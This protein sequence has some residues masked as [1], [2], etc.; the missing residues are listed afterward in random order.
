MFTM[1][2]YKRPQSIEEAFE[3]LNAKKPNCILGGTHF[4]KMG[5]K[6]IAT[7]ID[8]QDVGLDY[9]KEE[10]GVIKIG[11]MTSLRTM[12]E[13]ELLEKH[14]GNVFKEAFSG[15][16]GI[17]LRNTATI[18]ASVHARYGFS[19]TCLVLLALEASVKLY[20]KEIIAIEQYLKE[21]LKKDFVTEI[22]I[23]IKT[24][25][26]TYK[27]YRK[28]ATDLSVLNVCVANE[29]G[30][31]PRIAVGA[32]PQRATLAKQAMESF[33]GDI[34]KTAITAKEEIIV[35]SNMR[36][37]SEYRSHLVKVLVA[38]ALQEVI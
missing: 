29:E 27:S 17:Q 30:K 16:V 14:Y 24:Q 6:V 5:K 4:L 26:V 37:S 31:N 20:D 25:K 38:R 10:N 15:I 28:S 2:E 34:E 1:R 11:A 36:G 13:S 23:P 7:G 22:A 12:E 9:I 3:L 8:L 32:R 21:T 19:D 18:G 35:G 33:Q